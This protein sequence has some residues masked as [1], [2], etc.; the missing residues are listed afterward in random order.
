MKTDLKRIL[1]IDDDKL[2]RSIVT[3]MVSRLGYDVL[4][5]DCGE[6]GLELFQK[7][8]FDLVITD[9]QMPGM[10]GINLAGLI[11]KNSPRTMVILMTGQDKESILPM[12]EDCSVD[13]ALFKPFSME[14]IQHKIQSVLAR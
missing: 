2:F 13:Q 7:N 1:V 12:V 6:T 10:N 8:G 11:K 3:Q 9:F 14:E 5:T 4:A